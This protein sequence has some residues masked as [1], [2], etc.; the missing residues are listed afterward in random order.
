MTWQCT[1]HTSNQR[2]LC[3]YP[4]ACCFAVLMPASLLL[5]PVLLLLLLPLPGCCPAH[6][7][8]LPQ[9]VQLPAL[10]PGFEALLQPLLRVLMLQVAVTLEGV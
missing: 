1:A 5:L 4:V 2:R 10:P 3:R 6:S 8:L 9:G 7:P